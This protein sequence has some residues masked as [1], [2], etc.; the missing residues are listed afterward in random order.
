MHLA[1]VSPSVALA[2][3]VSVLGQVWVSVPKNL[4]QAFLHSDLFF[5]SLGLPQI[6]CKGKK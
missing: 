3:Y 1:R 4:T 2:E 6:K 5:R